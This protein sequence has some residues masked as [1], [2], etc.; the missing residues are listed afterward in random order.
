MRLSSFA[1]TVL[2]SLAAVA[3]CSS[4]GSDASPAGPAASPSDATPGESPESHD[5]PKD[6]STKIVVGVD[7]EDFRSQGYLIGSVRIT[8]KVAGLVAAD[9]T[10]TTAPLFPHAMTLLAPKDAPDAPVEITVVAR[11]GGSESSDDGTPPVVTRTATTKFVKDKTKLAYVFLEVR[12]N[13]FPLGGGGVLSGPTCT[14]AGETCIGGKCRSDALGDLPDYATDWATNPPSLCGAGATP[15]IELGK[16]ETDFAPLAAN[17]TVTIQSGA[18]CGHHL[19]LGVRTTAIAQHGATTIV[20]ATQPGSGVTVPPTAVPYA[21]APAS[22]G[23]C[24]LPGIRFQVDLGGAK[25][26]DFLGKPLDVTVQAKDKAGHTATATK[27]VNVA[28]TVDGSFPYCNASKDG[29][30]G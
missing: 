11:E 5:K 16:G 4:S 1:A 23:A 14:N 28:P 13:T 24:E 29:G 9:E 7:A 8:A 19:W 17:E 15:T 30:A 21:Y 6:P 22:D 27:R 10:V 26:E 12:C 18:Q 3:A 25:V 20:S 2:V